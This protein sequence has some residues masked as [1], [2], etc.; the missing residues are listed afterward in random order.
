MLLANMALLMLL[1][2]LLLW[3]LL[4]HELLW[5]LLQELLRVFNTVLMNLGDIV[6]LKKLWFSG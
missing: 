6:V 3:E 1:C 5:W 4:L 2:V